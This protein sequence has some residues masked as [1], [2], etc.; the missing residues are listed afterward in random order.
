MILQE[1]I[2]ENSDTVPRA[3]ALSVRPCVTWEELDHFRDSWNHLLSEN[4]LSS[5]FQTP[6]W[7]AAW[8]QAF[9][10]GKKLL[11]L[12]FSD[13]DGKTLGIAPLYIE[14]QFFSGLSLKSLR[15]V[16][17]GSGD[18]DALDFIAAPGYERHC[19]EAFFT[20][21]MTGA[22]WDI[23]SLETLPQNSLVGK[24]LQDMTQES[25][26]HVETSLTPN[27]VID[28]PTT[29]NEYLGTLESSFR[30]LLTRYPKRLQT[31]F[32]VEIIRSTRVE[33]LPEQLQ[34]LFTLHQMRW[35]G[36]GEP[37]AFSSDERRDFYLRMSKSFLQH[38]WLEFWLLS[39]DGET[40]G[41][42]FCFRYN[43]TVSLLQEGFHPKYTAEKIG[44][45]LRAHVLEEA[46]KTGAQHYDFLGGADSYKANFGSRQAHY[47]NLSFAGPSNF[48]RAYLLLQ[49]QKQ[50]FKAWLRRNLPQKMLAILQHEN[51]SNA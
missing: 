4:P 46:I 37:G 33:D 25:G 41:T 13:S 31:R 10:K 51:K 19:A 44:Y 48:G 14:D 43:N 40:V 2:T 22:K 16:G 5:I 7:L 3:K 34:T 15:F 20:W 35:T 6:E 21:L 8:W 45:A 49:K 47:L 29:W 23:C 39:L 11:S 1:E 12:I 9:G 50:N 17:A 42:Q 30:P 28:L 26:W 36:R 32:K 27:F 38:G 18:S 24:Y